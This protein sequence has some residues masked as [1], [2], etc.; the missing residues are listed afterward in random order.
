[1]RAAAAVQVCRCATRPSV[2]LYCSSY[3]R[4]Q[5]DATDCGPCQALTR[6][7]FGP[8]HSRA[9]RVFGFVPVSMFASVLGCRVVHGDRRVTLYWL[10]ECLKRGVLLPPVCRSNPVL[11]PIPRNLPLPH[12]VGVK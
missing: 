9:L 7:N 8:P 12:M 10:E 11:R 4:L 6:Y 2:G 3:V 1:M 5:F